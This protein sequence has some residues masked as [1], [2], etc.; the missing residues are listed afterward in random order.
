MNRWIGIINDNG[1]LVLPEYDPINGKSYTFLQNDNLTILYSGDGR[2]SNDQLFG[3]YDSSIIL[4]DGVILNLSELKKNNNCDTIEDLIKVL[5]SE[6]LFYSTFR[7]P[8]AGMCYDGKTKHMEAFGNQTG[9][10]PLFY[11]SKASSLFVSNDLDLIV[12][13]FRANH[14]HYTYNEKAALYLMTYGY[15][16]DESTCINEIK[17]LSAGR[18]IE[19]DNGIINILRY[20][21]FEYEDIDISFEQAIDMINEGFIKAVKRCF[22]KDIEYGI[23][24][25]LVDMSGGLDS[26]M[27][28]WVA[29]YLG[30]KGIT[31]ISYSQSGSNEHKYASQVSKTLGHEFIHKQLDDASFLFEIDTIV[32]MN[33]GLTY[34]C[35]ITGGRQLLSSI[36]AQKYG[37]EFAGQLGDVVIGNYGN[38]D[39]HV[40]PVRKSSRNSHLIKFEPSDEYYNQ[41]SDNEDFTFENRGFRSIL[42]THLTRR[43]YFYAV[44]P[45][46]DVDFMQM[47]FKIPMKYRV[48]HILYW[49]WIDKYYPEA[50]SIPS[51]RSR[52]TTNYKKAV[53]RGIRFMKRIMRKSAHALR[54]SK[55]VNSENHMNPFEYWFETIPELRA[56][57]E[58]Y[59]TDTRELAN[60]YPE[61]AHNID[62]MYNSERTMDKLLAL[63]VLG[64]LKR[65]FK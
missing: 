6:R 27:V 16:L 24:S 41:Y 23:N 45:F 21:R 39:A 17:R 14:I 3:S 13:V 58:K 30:Y 11:Y 29:H 1:K 28:S 18:Y 49:A 35:G 40:S 22:D 33:Y 7:G 44:S 19:W 4:L 42:S 20:H 50:G 34:Y 12:E 9:D 31:N 8:F 10:S 26:R 61:T 25:H 38:T 36:N 5:K 53:E 65:Y 54:I 64:G 62:I 60:P 46:I 52:A 43:H 48:N 2:F 15:M 57:I 63:T 32:S 47:C 37:L 55:S 51:T 59:Y 56:F